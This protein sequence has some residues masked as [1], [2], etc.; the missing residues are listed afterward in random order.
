M[1]GLTSPQIRLKK[2]SLRCV[3][4]SLSYW[5][6]REGSTPSSTSGFWTL[7]KSAQLGAGS[8]APEPAPA[9]PPGLMPA[10]PAAPPV[11][12]VLG[13]AGGSVGEPQATALSSKV[14]R[15]ARCL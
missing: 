11:P 1:L 5:A 9:E 7:G 8:I 14:A 15:A 13:G 12:P 3:P 2:A 4:H 6:S 10:P